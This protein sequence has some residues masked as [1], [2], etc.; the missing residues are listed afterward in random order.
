MQIFPKCTLKG[1]DAR[2]RDCVVK[3]ATSP[4][5][6]EVR[7]PTDMAGN[8]KADIFINGQKAGDAVNV[9]AKKSG[10]KDDVKLMGG[11]LFQ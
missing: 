10:H 1:P 4:Q 7:W 8:Y 6:Y 9:Y 11:L 3:E 2:P 5:Q